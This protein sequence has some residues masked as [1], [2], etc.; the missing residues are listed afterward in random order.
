MFEQEGR[1]MPVPD[2]HSQ[3][4]AEREARRPSD[5]LSLP[6]GPGAGHIEVSRSM[7]TIARGLGLMETEEAKP[8]RAPRSVAELAEEA[9]DEWGVAAQADPRLAQTLQATQRLLQWIR[10]HVA[11]FAEEARLRP[12]LNELLRRLRRFK[13]AAMK[14]ARRLLAVRRAEKLHHMAENAWHDFLANNPE[15]GTSWTQGDWKQRRGR[16]LSTLEARAAELTDARARVT[17]EEQ[18][19]CEKEASASAAHLEAWSW[20]ML[21]RYP[22]QLDVANQPD[23]ARPGPAISVP[24]AP[25]P[26]YVPKPPRFH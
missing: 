7:A 11:A 19:L 12:D 3:A 25:A 24:P 23:G 4:Q 13:A 26:V 14:F 20:D 18:A 15:P 17:P 8:S 5:V 1:A 9:S 21:Q 22:L 10:E 2:G 16:R 6:L